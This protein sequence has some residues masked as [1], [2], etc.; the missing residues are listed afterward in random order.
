MLFLL[1][2]VLYYAYFLLA[3]IFAFYRYAPKKQT[4]KK[5]FFSVIVPFRNEEKSLPELL[6]S[7]QNVKYDLREVLLVNDHSEDRS[8]EIVRAEIQEDKCFR[9]LDLPENLQG[10][11]AA[12][13]YGISQAKGEII[14]TTDADCIVPGEWISE[15]NSYFTEKTGLVLGAVRLVPENT[16]EK[17]QAIEFAGLMVLACGGVAKRSPDLANAA[18]FAYRKKVFEEVNGFENIDDL[19][20]GDDEFFLQKVRKTSWEIQYAKTSRA[21]VST[22]GMNTFAQLVVQRIRWAGKT[23]KY[24]VQQKAK[25]F[26]IFLAYVS[27]LLLPFVDIQYFAVAFGIKTFV[28]FL[29]SFVGMRFLRIK[30][31]VFSLFLLALFYVPFVAYIGII[32]LFQKKYTWKNRK[33][34]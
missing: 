31:S 12:I 4:G 22:K 34:I 18:N 33:T 13:S 24:P 3:R 19:A 27:L 15:I 1:L 20:S 29:L 30:I 6:R 32:S 21:I 8:R 5:Y 14:L 11:K 17:L 23:R 25:L 7:L 2:P 10:K 28:D 26:P 9:L 16:L